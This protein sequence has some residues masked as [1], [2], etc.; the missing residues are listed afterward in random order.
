MHRVEVVDK[1][2]HGL[3]STVVRFGEG[4]PAG[5][6]LKFDQLRLVGFQRRGEDLPLGLVPFGVVR[7][8]DGAPRFGFGAVFRVFDG[9][10]RVEVAK[11]YSLRNVLRT[12]SAMP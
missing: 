8:A 4:F 3:I 12:P 2:L 11:Q 7:Q 10:L 1:R 5:E 9:G 6:S